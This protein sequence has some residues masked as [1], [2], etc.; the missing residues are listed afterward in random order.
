ML[1][2][3]VLSGDPDGRKQTP[4]LLQSLSFRSPFSFLPHPGICD[5]GD[6]LSRSF[7]RTHRAR[8]LPQTLSCVSAD[9]AGFGASRVGLQDQAVCAE[10]AGS[11]DSSGRALATDAAPVRAAEIAHS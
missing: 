5:S 1:Y 9:C 7:S 11:S 10:G 2:T 8:W 4:E 6:L 3:R